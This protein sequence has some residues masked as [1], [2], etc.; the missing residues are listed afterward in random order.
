M[1][2]IN[3]Q[4]VGW[5]TT[6]Y[7]GPT[8]MNHMDDGIKAAC[9]GVDAANENLG[10]RNLQTYYTF[11]Q[12]GCTVN[13]TLAEVMAALPTNS[14]LHLTLSASTTGNFV[15]DMPTTGAP[16]MVV[17]SKS[18]DSRRGYATYKRLNSSMTY[19]QI[20]ENC[21][22][23]N[24]FV[25]WE[26][27]AKNSDLANKLD[28]IKAGYTSGGVQLE[29]NAPSSY[30]IYAQGGAEQGNVCNLWIVSRR[31]VGDA[32]SIVPIIETWSV[33][34]ITLSGNTVTFGISGYNFLYS[35]IQLV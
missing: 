14:E 15:N 4:K 22:I 13:N 28:R 3:Y 30:L 9:D 27:T 11:A 7:F 10:K 34:P 26:R 12:I 6:S 24:A 8:N 17:L 18:S 21:Y 32:V 16:A 29:V 2:K 1:A 23:E 25:G 20:Y 31:N 35:I 5:N 19:T 33:A